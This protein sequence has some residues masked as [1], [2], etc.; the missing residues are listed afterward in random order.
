MVL[1]NILFFAL[2]LILLVKGS[3]FLVKS[4]ATLA[5]KLGVSEFIIGVTLVSLGTS[6][7]ELALAI[8]ASIKQQSGLII[9]NIVGANI[10][11]IGLITGVAATIAIIKT[12]KEMLKR[13][14]YIMLFAAIIFY[15]FILNGL[16]S[17]IEAILLLL[18][19]SAYILFLYEVES[20]F[21]AKY[22]FKEFID[23]FFKL[24]YLIIPI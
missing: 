23:Y 10:A 20:K 18:L 24:K 6:I 11:N 4:A 12:K 17:R 14:G 22:H 1:E 7:P 16:I 9:G 13:D 3:D 21:K 5:K 19:Y 15:I 8:I 2:G